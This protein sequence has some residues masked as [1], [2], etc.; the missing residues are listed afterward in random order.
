ML[1]PKSV[2]CLCLPVVTIFFQFL[3]VAILYARLVWA[4]SS[5]TEVSLKSKHDRD[6]WRIF[7]WKEE[8]IHSCFIECQW[9]ENYNFSDIIYKTYPVIL[10]ILEYCPIMQ[11]SLIDRC[12]SNWLDGFKMLVCLVFD[13]KLTTY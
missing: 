5:K 4:I 3:I 12:N 1:C 6:I 9:S 10:Q 13:R 8:A 2:A 11:S 7:Y